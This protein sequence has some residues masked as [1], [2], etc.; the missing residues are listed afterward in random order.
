[1]SSLFVQ[2]CQ[3]VRVQLGGLPCRMGAFL[4]QRETNGNTALWLKRHSRR[5]VTWYRHQH[6]VHNIQPSA[7]LREQLWE[8]RKGS[9]TQT[10]SSKFIFTTPL[11][12]IH[13][14]Y[15]L[16]LKSHFMWPAAVWVI[17]WNVSISFVKLYDSHRLT[18][19]C[20]TQYPGI[21]CLRQPHIVALWPGSR[22]QQP[23]IFH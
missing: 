10:D 4:A 21:W 6:V 3:T 23:V 16:L 18:L 5:S 8:K 7:S 12:V 9:R 19:D 13:Q 11:N 2:C 15:L 17:H 1:M 14:Q 20:K 22:V